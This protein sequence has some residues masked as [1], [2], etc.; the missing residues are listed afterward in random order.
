MSLSA[1]ERETVITYNDDEKE[2]IVY[3]CNAALR[4]KLE[5]ISADRPDECK[6]ARQNEFY[7]EYTLPKKWVKIHPSRILS[8]EQKAE[9]AERAKRLS[10]YR[11]SAEQDAEPHSV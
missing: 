2:A 6:L 9:Y 3:T 8:G 10:Q 11:K 7:V 1:Y 4:R 5:S